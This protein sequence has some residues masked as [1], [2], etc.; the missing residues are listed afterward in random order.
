METRRLGIWLVGAFGGVGTSI[1]LGLAALRRGLTS[2]TGLVTELPKFRQLRFASFDAC[3]IGGH[4]VRRT[5]FCQS[6]AELHKNSRVF[7]TELLAQC[8]TDLQEWSQ[9]VRPGVLALSGRP[10]EQ[11]ADWHGTTGA[12][13]SLDLIA[14]LADDLAEFAHRHGL[15]HTVVL[16][17]ASSEPMVSIGPELESWSRLEPALRDPGRHPIPASSLYA[18]AACRSRA[19]YVN[20]TPSLGLDAPALEECARQA[21]ILY[22]GKDGKTGETLL[23]SVLAPMFLRRNL[24]VIS[25]VGHN[26]LGNRDGLVLQDP[27]NKQGKLATKGRLLNEILG[28]EP[29]SLVSIEHVP[30]LADWK[31]AWD[32]IHFQGFLGAK[33]SLQFIWQGCDSLLAAPLAIDLVRWTDLAQCRGQTGCLTHLAAYFKSPMHVAEHDFFGQC[34]LLTDYARSVGGE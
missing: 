30:S 8:A 34:Q 29:Q 18:L 19:S 14:T 2:T 1:A 4:D 26:I 12:K 16:N 23:K 5:S 24:D 6:A 7:S 21:G 22:A 15:E 20:F 3:V 25:W 9:N 32:H 11:F 33:M 28:Y 27:T 31:I 13:S 17:V 10:V